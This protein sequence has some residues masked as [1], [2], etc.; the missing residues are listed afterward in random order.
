MWPLVPGEHAEELAESIE[1]EEKRREEKGKSV[2]HFASPTDGI[3]M[4]APESV[5]VSWALSSRKGP[6]H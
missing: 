2:D 3:S 5:R 6:K 4:Q 1:Q